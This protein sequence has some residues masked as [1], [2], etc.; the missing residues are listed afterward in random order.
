MYVPQMGRDFC[1]NSP[2][3]HIRRGM[4]MVLIDE[5]SPKT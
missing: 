2:E 3:A 1:R 4:Q 5:S